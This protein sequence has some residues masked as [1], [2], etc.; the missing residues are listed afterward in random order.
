MKNILIVLGVILG[1]AVLRQVVEIP[2]KN[3]QKL[4]KKM[5]P[6]WTIKM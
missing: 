3:P 1:I 6:L 5:R 2:N 4:K